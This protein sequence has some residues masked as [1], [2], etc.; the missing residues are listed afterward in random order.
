MFGNKNG[1][2]ILFLIS[3]KLKIKIKRPIT[4]VIINDQKTLA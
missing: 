1:S 4:H 2:H 3:G